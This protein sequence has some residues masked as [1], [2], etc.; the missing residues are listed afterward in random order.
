MEQCA[1]RCKYVASRTLPT[2]TYGSLWNL[3]FTERIHSTRNN[4]ASEPNNCLRL[5][6][7][8]PPYLP[9]VAA[10]EV[11]ED[12]RFVSSSRLR[13]AERSFSLTLHPVFLRQFNLLLIQLI[14]CEGF[15][16]LFLAALSSRRR[17]MAT[18]NRYLL[19]QTCD[20]PKLV[21]IFWSRPTNRIRRRISTLFK[22]ESRTADLI[23]GTR[24]DTVS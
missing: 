20:Q 10:Q 21:S 14:F 19:N 7:A 1:H 12:A 18:T 16:K 13:H 3:F 4:S 23:L 2:C 15:F 5:C 17:S 9:S 24:I 6:V 8:F 22:S 11:K